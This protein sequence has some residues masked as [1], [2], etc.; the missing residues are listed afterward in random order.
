MNN[1]NIPEWKVKYEIGIPDVD[2]QHKYFLELIK[3]FYERINEGMAEELTINHINEIILYTQFHFCSEENIMKLY[4]YPNIESHRKMHI[5]ILQNLSDKISLYELKE[6][7][8]DEIM[9]FLVHW[10]LNHTIN[11]DIKLSQFIKK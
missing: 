9:S 8:L 10:F 2:F 4:G 6:I 5:E 7:S 1:S 3:R 11:E